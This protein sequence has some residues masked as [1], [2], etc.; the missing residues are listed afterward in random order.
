MCTN[1]S[2]AAFQCTFD[3]LVELAVRTQP[4]ARKTNAVVDDHARHKFNTEVG[5]VYMLVKQHFEGKE[6]V[7]KKMF[8]E[9][10]PLFQQ[11]Y[12]HNK[13]LRYV[14]LH[15][16]FKFV[17]Q[18]AKELFEFKQVRATVDAKYYSCTERSYEDVLEG[19][20]LTKKL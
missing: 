19:Y 1:L 18:V 15:T 10:Y 4:T 9:L 17:R 5:T 14:N 3:V 2:K 20:G 13:E 8:L 6:F 11:H 16:S 12:E 7:Q